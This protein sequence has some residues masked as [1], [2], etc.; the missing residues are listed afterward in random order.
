MDPNLLRGTVPTLILSVLERGPS[1]GYE[2]SETIQSLTGGQLKLSVAAL[3]TT[4]KRLEEQGFIRPCEGPQQGARERRYV[5][6]EPAGRIFL[7]EKR[8]EWNTFSAMT[9]A[10]LLGHRPRG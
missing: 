10:I 4:L 2:I 1:Y 9:D 8:A 5:A 7:S 3:Y 6:I